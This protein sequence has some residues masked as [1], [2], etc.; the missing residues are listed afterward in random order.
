MAEENKRR[1][2]DKLFKGLI[3]TFLFEF[4]ELFFPWLASKL[5]KETLK[6]LGTELINKKDFSNRYAD[7]VFEVKLKAGKEIIIHIEGQNQRLP[8]YNQMVY[9]YNSRLYEKY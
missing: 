3:D 1:K 4:L 8:E 2:H 6:S 7:L 5:E 9:I